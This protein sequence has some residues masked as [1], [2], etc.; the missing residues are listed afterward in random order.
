MNIYDR[1]NKVRGKIYSEMLKKRQQKLSLRLCD[2][3]IVRKWT[4]N[5]SHYHVHE[6]RT[7]SKRFTWCKKTFTPSSRALTKRRHELIPEHFPQTLTPRT[8]KKLYPRDPKHIRNQLRCDRNART[9]NA[10]EKERYW[11]INPMHVGVELLDKHERTCDWDITQWLPSPT[12]NDRGKGSVDKVR[13]NDL[14]FWMNASS[15]EVLRKCLKG[16]IITEPDVRRW[17]ISR[18]RSTW[19]KRVPSRSGFTFRCHRHD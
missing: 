7:F 16:I 1:K 4:Q 15:R 10:S 14:A 3:V 5:K 19:T 12:V 11:M 17:G 2:G 9:S 8:V 13:Q 6:S 18:W